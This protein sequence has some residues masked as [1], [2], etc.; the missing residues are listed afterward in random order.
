MARL[1]F[2]VFTLIA[3]CGWV[4]SSCGGGDDSEL[5][6]VPVDTGEISLEDDFFESMDEDYHLPSPL[7]VASIFKKSGLEFNSDAPNKTSVA[8]DYTD[9]LKQ[10]LNFGVYSADMAYCVLNEQANTGRQ[11][12]TV[13]TELAGKIGMEAVFENE[14]LM[15]RF[16]ANMENKDSIEILMI[17]I[18]E[19]TENYMEENDMQHTSAIHFA[20]AWTE[21]MYLGVYDYEHN[22]GKEGVGAQLT[23]QMAILGN[24]IKGLKDPRNSGTD[25]GW[26]ISSLETIQNTF[27]GFESVNAFYEDE[28]A[29][30]LVLKTEEIDELGALIKDLRAKIITA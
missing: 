11:Y 21:G 19:R 25:L 2:T 10:M 24:I 13:I 16:D 7:Q 5:T 12:L 26:V 3:L 22:P 20:G 8:S 23:E 14:D 29:D 1:K 4:I 27:N 30:E 9:E 6:D 18:H 28:N 15:K 17:D